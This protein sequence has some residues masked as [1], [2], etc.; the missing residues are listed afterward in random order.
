MTIKIFLQNATQYIQ[1]NAKQHNAIQYNATQYN[2]IR[3]NTITCN[4]M[5][6]ERVVVLQ[7]GM[8]PTAKQN[9]RGN[10]K[11]LKKPKG[12]CQNHSKTIEKTQKNQKNLIFFRLQV[13]GTLAATRRA[14]YL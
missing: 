9:T 8:G 1:C 11:K 5:G 4:T 6:E 12:S 10:P 2:S 14:Q 7:K 3:C 13:L